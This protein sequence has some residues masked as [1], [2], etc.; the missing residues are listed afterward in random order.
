MLVFNGSCKKGICVPQY[1]ER[2]QYGNCDLGLFSEAFTLSIVFNKPLS[3]TFNFFLWIAEVLVGSGARTISIV[4]GH[5]IKQDHTSYC[6]RAGITICHIQGHLAFKLLKNSP[7]NNKCE[8]LTRLRSE[9]LHCK[10]IEHGVNNWYAITPHGLLW[11]LVE[12]KYSL[13][14][15]IT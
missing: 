6:S 3:D 5:W 4:G 9:E 15:S 14:V 12:T 10:S 7:Q 2:A 8:A 13:T 11:H 1:D